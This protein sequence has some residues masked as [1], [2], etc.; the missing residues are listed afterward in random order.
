[1]EGFPF[2]IPLGVFSLTTE[3]HTGPPNSCSSFSSCAHSDESTTFHIKAPK[4]CK[5]F[6]R[7]PW[8]KWRKLQK[9]IASRGAFFTS[10]TFLGMSETSGCFFSVKSLRQGE[11]RFWY[12]SSCFKSFKGG[13]RCDDFFQTFKPFRQSPQLKNSFPPLNLRLTSADKCL[14][15]LYTLLEGQRPQI[16]RLCLVNNFEPQPCL[17]KLGSSVTK[18][19]N[20]FWNGSWVNSLRWKASIL[21]DFEQL[22]SQVISYL[23]RTLGNFYQR[24]STFPGGFLHELTR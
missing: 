3:I 12:C 9:E 7:L 13:H 17:E 20:K 22:A 23:S 5:S 6:T 21:R 19:A 4:H 14:S 15:F 18:T 11:F 24:P 8:K 2:Y 10:F 1:M 16:F